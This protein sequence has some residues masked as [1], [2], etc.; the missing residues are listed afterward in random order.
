MS[1]LSTSSLSSTP[2]RRIIL[3]GGTG[4]LGK[5]TAKAFLASDG[6]SE[7]IL[8]SRRAVVP[9]DISKLG[10]QISAMHIDVTNDRSVDDAIRGA[11]VVVNLVGI[12]FGPFNEIQHLGA[13]RIAEFAKKHNV[14][15]LVHISAIGANA[16][17]SVPYARSKAFGEKAVLDTL[18]TAAVVLRPSLVFGREDDFFNVRFPFNFD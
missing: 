6:K 13:K 8:A 10:N 16:S 4:F 14:R 9:D 3:V 1:T 17:S 5:Y 12:M 2:P 18:G 11:D 15:K 7:I